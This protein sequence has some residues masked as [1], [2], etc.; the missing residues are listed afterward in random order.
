MHATEARRFVVREGRPGTGK[1]LF[2][3]VPIRKGDFILEYTGKKIPTK[4]ADE[5][6]SRYLFEIDKKWT[7]N[8]PVPKNTAGYINH[9]CDPNVEAIIEEGDDDRIM[10]YALRDIPAGAELTIDYGQEYFD[11]FIKPTGCKCSAGKHRR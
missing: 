7:I 6:S 9:A 3:K 4:I 2:A 5:M 11:E 1:G 10:I 8:G